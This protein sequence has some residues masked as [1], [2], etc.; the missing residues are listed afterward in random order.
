MIDD[1]IL[2]TPLGMNLYREKIEE[3][4]DELK[5]LQ[6][7]TAYIAE[8]GGDQYHDNASYESLVIDIRGL[9][10]RISEMHKILNKSVIISHV[11]KDGKVRIGSIVKVIYWGKEACLH[12][13]GYGESDPKQN[14]IAYDAPLAALIMGKEEDDIVSGL[15]AGKKVEIEILEITYNEE[16]CNDG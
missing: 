3:L 12:I 10:W 15:I 4:D 7:E 1:Q 16:K 14:K 8:V 2:F 6:A 13:V 11:V 9:D 5:K